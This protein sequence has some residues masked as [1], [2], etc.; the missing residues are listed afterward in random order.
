MSDTTDTYYEDK[1]LICEGCKRP[2]VFTGGE[3]R[4]FAEKGFTPPKRCKPCRDERKKQREEE[5]KQRGSGTGNGDGQRRQRGN[6]GSGPRQE[7]SYD[8]IWSTKDDFFVRD[9]RRERR[10][11]RRRDRGDRKPR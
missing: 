1:E 6:D 9:D 10:R 2:F 4:F 7:R 8:E 3:Q 11:K 5:R